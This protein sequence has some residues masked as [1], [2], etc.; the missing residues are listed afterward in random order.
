M[1]LLHGSVYFA[2]SLLLKKRRRRKSG[3]SGYKVRFFL[4][5]PPPPSP[6][7]LV[8]F[9]QSVHGSEKGLSRPP[10]EI[11]LSGKLALRR[12]PVLFSCEPF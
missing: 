5:T 10:Y 7:F 11:V 12:D 1:L 9:Q 8:F 6:F 3:I 2:A 4:L